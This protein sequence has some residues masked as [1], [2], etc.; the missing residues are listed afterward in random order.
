MKNKFRKSNGAVIRDDEIEFLRSA[1]EVEGDAAEIERHLQTLLRWAGETRI[2]YFLFNGLL[3][4]EFRATVSP[5]GEL[6][7]RGGTIIRH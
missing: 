4:G 7:F 3:D 1:L 6:M 5:D 2:N